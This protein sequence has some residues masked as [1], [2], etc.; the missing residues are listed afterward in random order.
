[1]LNRIKQQ[2]FSLLCIILFTCIA[3]GQEWTRFRG[4]NGQ[5]I[6]KA[7]NIPVKWTEKDY[8]W[9][10]KLP[11]GGHSSPVIWKDK[12]FITCEDPD[13]A[14]GIVLALDVSD[15]STLWTK[16]Y[17][18]TAYKKHN[19]NNYATATPVVN[20]K[21]VYVLWQSNKESIIAALDHNGKIIWR[22][23]LPGVDSRFGPGTSPTVI[24]DI[25]VF[26]HEHRND[27]GKNQS[28]WL[29][30][31]RK[32]GQTRWTK[33]RSYG[34]ISYSTPCIYRPESNDPLFIFTS[35]EHGF[36]AVDPSNGSIIWEIDSVLPARVVSSPVIV[37]ELLIS[38]CGRGGA[39]RQ[40]SVIR[41]GSRDNSR[42]PDLIYKTTGKFAPYVP[43][44][45]VKDGLMFLYHDRGDISCLRLET[46]VEVWSEKPGDRFYGSPV[47]VD[48]LLYC[49]SREGNVL[50]IKA[51]DKYELVAINPLGEGSQATPAIS[52]GRI[53]LR[54]YSHLISI[55]N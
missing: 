13:S 6:S 42:K 21:H 49:I 27:D 10:I 32:T 5:G 14:G 3:H 7:K 38:T 22:R 20:A 36:S 39:G 30:F 51:A 44:P 43:T 11:A 16:K 55:G 23:D 54:S 4:P 40:L 17:K 34:Q 45:L 50:I 8:N 26:S 28:A 2:G 52:D 47:W 12:V 1:M 37:G 19:D 18:L 33:E 46:G 53:Y 31:D 9:K 25:I 24:N 15:G 48:G 41:A 35:M 29:A